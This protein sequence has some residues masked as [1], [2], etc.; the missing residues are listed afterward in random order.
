MY[1]NTITMRRHVSV[2]IVK[3]LPQVIFITSLQSKISLLKSLS[4]KCGTVIQA[5]YLA[6]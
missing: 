4:Y 6:V 5:L 2:L 3:Q 1:K